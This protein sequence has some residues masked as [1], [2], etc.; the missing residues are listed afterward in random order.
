MFA[1]EKHGGARRWNN[2]HEEAQSGGG[3]TTL[4]IQL[5]HFQWYSSRNL[6]SFFPFL[7]APP[8]AKDCFGIKKNFPFQ[9]EWKKKEKRKTFAKDFFS[10]SVKFSSHPPSVCSSPTTTFNINSFPHPTLTKKN[11]ARYVGWRNLCPAG[12]SFAFLM[13]VFSSA[14]EKWLSRDNESWAWRFLC[15]EKRRSLVL[16]GNDLRFALIIIFRVEQRPDL[17]S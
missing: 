13:W 3:K 5:S 10:F 7:C 9:N 14:E 16:Y 11:R 6:R 8:V 17:K 4:S 2:K 12:I 15:H 1:P